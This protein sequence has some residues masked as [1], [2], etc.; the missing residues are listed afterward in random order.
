MSPEY[1]RAWRQYRRRRNAFVV[2]VLSFPVISC[3]VPLR[4]LGLGTNAWGVIGVAWLALWGV[5]GGSLSLWKCPRCGNTYF[6]K[7]ATNGMFV[8]H[9]MHCGLPKWAL[10]P[11]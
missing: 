5:L 8:R 4:S 9:C 3:L 10:D 2:S 7:S 1:Q 11:P 6:Q